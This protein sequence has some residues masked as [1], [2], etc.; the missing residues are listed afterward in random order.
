[1]RLTDRTIQANKRWSGKV[2]RALR[3][4]LFAMDWNMDLEE[5][6]EDDDMNPWRLQ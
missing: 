6:E 3:R 4:R 2:E 1:M 5:S